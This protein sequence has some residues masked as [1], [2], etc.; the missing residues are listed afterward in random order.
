MLFQTILFLWGISVESLVFARG[1]VL[2]PGAEAKNLDPAK[3][4]FLYQQNESPWGSSKCSHVAFN[5][6][7]DWTVKC[8]VKGS[9][10]SYL[11]HLALNFYPS[12]NFG[13]SA[14]ELLY[15]ITDHSIPGQAHFASTTVWLHNSMADARGT[16]IEAALG[17]EED[18]ASLRL[19]I[20]LQ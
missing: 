17:L 7:Y 3:L 11:V 13:K 1:A 19:A 10:K 2:R 4:S 12:S 6:Y 18:A 20:D 14:Y 5:E 9:P 16:L 15:W 8:E